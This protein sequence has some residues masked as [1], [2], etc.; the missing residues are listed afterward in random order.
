MITKGNIVGMPVLLVAFTGLWG[1]LGFGLSL[2]LCTSLLDT[3]SERQ[4]QN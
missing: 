1:K 3:L 4:D 2:C